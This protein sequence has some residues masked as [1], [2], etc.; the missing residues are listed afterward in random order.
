MEIGRLAPL[1]LA[2]GLI[3]ETAACVHGG[4]PPR[5]R[6]GAPQG[7][8]AF[9]ERRADAQMLL[10][11]DGNG[12]GEV[13]RTELDGLLTHSFAQADRS[14][15][16]RLDRDEMRA[17]DDLRWRTDGNAAS[18]LVDWNLDGGVD[19]VEFASM[20]HSLFDAFDRNHDGIVTAEELR[21]QPA[22]ARGGGGGQGGG[23][24]G[25]GGRGG[26]GRRE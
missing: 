26:G 25:R 9:G 15:D 16:G 5:G 22:G 17:E 11:Y 10:R 8:P 3:L 23:R 19:F 20:A 7:Q 21:A 2:V 13:S 14:S 6:G 18:P 4:P 1:L 24:G 12:D